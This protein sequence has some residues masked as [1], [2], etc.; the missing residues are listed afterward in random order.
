MNSCRIGENWSDSSTR[1]LI[2]DSKLGI[3][4]APFFRFLELKTCRKIVSGGKTCVLQG[5]A[6]GQNTAQISLFRTRKPSKTCSW[7]TLFDRDRVRMHIYAVW[8]AYG[9]CRALRALQDTS[10]WCMS[11]P[12]NFGTG[13]PKVGSETGSEACPRPK[14]C[15]SASQM[16]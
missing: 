16:T 9:A 14:K 13:Y 8:G 10:V 5:P 3:F 6:Q 4:A 1:I 12:H 15:L 7:V 2:A 11:L